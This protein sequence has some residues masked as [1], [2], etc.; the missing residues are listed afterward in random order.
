MVHELLFLSPTTFTGLDQR[1]QNLARLF[2]RNGFRVHFVE[3]L[4]F[5]LLQPL[6]SRI[7]ATL[8][9]YRPCFWW[10]SSQWPGLHSVAVRLTGRRLLRQIGVQLGDTWLWV[11][12]PSWAVLSRAAWRGVAYD[13]CDRHGWFPGQRPA[14]WERYE[15]LLLA[16]ARL[17]VASHPRLRDSLLKRGAQQV[18]LVGNAARSNWLMPAGEQPSARV[19]GPPWRLI[20]I[21][22]H[23]EWLDHDWLNRWLHDRNDVELHLAGS[24]RGQAFLRLLDHPQVRWHGNLA[25]DR[26]PALLD[27]AHVGLLP[28]VSSPL[29]RCVDPIKLYDYAARKLP[30]WTTSAFARD[31]WSAAPVALRA[32]AVEQ[33]AGLPIAEL[34]AADSRSAAKMRVETWENRFRAIIDG[35]Q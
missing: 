11:A 2:S 28:F 10:R 13:C 32:I 29:T 21:G 27:T 16:H 3:P 25:A 33:I 9:V 23:F 7:T 24:G 19:A 31:G 14:V 8:H 26:L 30:V 17:I 20:S 5:G 18:R 1:H 6:P 35:L 15:A 12:D 34:L 22:A 4:C